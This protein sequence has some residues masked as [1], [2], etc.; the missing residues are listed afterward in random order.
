MSTKHH[1]NEEAKTIMAR[2][3]EYSFD[4]LHPLF[5]EGKTPLFKEIE[6]DTTGAFLAWNPK[7][8]WLMK[9]LTM[10]GFDNP[11]A[12]WL[13][14]RFITTFNG[15][16]TGKGVNLYKNRIL[17]C[18]FQFDTSIEKALLDTN[19]CL[20]L[21]YA[22]FPSPMFGTRDELRKIEDGIFLGQGHHKFPWEK[23]YSFL[24]YFV[25]CAST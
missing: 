24:V 3:R 1:S 9:F 19:S 23:E 25:L 14:K 21:D 20:V 6:G 15:E 10:I 7:T 22:A 11:F 17:S 18:R 5:K 12:R 13:G 4:D 8:S 2:F 16:R